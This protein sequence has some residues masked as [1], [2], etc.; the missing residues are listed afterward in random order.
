[1]TGIVRHVHVYSRSCSLF[2][3]CIMCSP[4]VRAAP[5][6]GPLTP[7]YFQRR[8]HSPYLMLGIDY[9]ALRD[10]I[11]RHDLVTNRSCTVD[12][13]DPRYMHKFSRVKCIA[14]RFAGIIADDNSR[15]DARTKRVRPDQ[16]M[17]DTGRSSFTFAPIRAHFTRVSADKYAR[18]RLII[19]GRILRD[20]LQRECYMTI[21][22]M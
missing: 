21:G 22:E 10:P 3:V 18:G 4:C 17:P 19:L 8:T 7:V 20:K 14:K 12:F 6:W 11:R 15:F 2:I 5:F 16:N 9:N 1:M 13:E